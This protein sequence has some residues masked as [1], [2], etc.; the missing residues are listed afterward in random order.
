[1]KA[2]TV[3]IEP[4]SAFGTPLRGD[5]LFGQLCWTIADLSG[6]ES[7]K[8]LLGGYLSGRPFAVIGDPGP[9][10]WLPRPSCPS[11]LWL[12]GT[13]LDPSERKAEKARAWVPSAMA[14]QPLPTWRAKANRIDWITTETSM[15]NS[16]NRLSGT[17]GTGDGFSPYQT[18]VWR[19]GDPDGQPIALELV[20]VVD[21]QRLPL[22]QLESA[23]TTI[24]QLG[25]G[26]DASTGKGRFRVRQLAEATLHTPARPDAWLTLGPCAP[27]G[28][29]WRAE[30]CWYNPLIRFG[31]HGNTAALTGHPFK[32]PVVLADCGALLT[33]AEWTTPLFCGQGLGGGDVLSQSLAGTVHQ[34]YAPVIPVHTGAL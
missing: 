17:T 30:R 1:V 29:A 19:Y 11:K 18:E 28:L 15:H 26:K 13:D 2:Y 23:L 31:R 6:E 20:V 25:Y 3:T 14:A 8:S 12:A 4:T 5:T 10:G 21:E 16:L 32:N 22:S 34:G 7:L 9:A 24:G 27:Q 33:P